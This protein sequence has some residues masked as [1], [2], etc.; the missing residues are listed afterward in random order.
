MWD[1]ARK[2]DVLIIEDNLGDFIIIEDYLKEEFLTV[3]VQHAKTFTIARKIIENGALF[4]LILLDLTLPDGTGEELV[5]EALLMAGDTPLIVLTGYSNKDFSIKTLAL[6]VSDYLLKDELDPA[7]LYKSISYSIERKKIANDLKHSEEKYRNLFNSSP[8]PMW[9]FDPETF[10]F[11]NVNAAACRHYGY[12]EEEFLSMSIMQIRPE[13][14]IKNVEQIVAKN[15]E[16]ANYY[17]GIFEHIKKNKDHIYVS[18]Q[19]NFIRFSEKASRLVVAA[20]VT[21]KIKAETALRIS[22]QRFKSLVQEGSDLICILDHEGNYKYVSPTSESILGLSPEYFLDKNAFDFIHSDDKDR[23]MNQFIRVVSEKRIQIEPYRFK[24]PE[25]SYRW[26]ETIVT[27]MMDDSSIDGVVANSRDV[28]D[29][30]IYEEKIRKK[31]SLF[32]ALI[33]KSS[34]MK[35]LI[36]LDGKI[37]FGTPSITRTLGYTAAEYI[38]MNERDLVH[39]D[40]VDDLFHKIKLSI[41]GEKSFENMQLRIKTKWGK[42]IWC[43][44][45]ITNL[46]DDPDVNAIVCNFWDIT[47]EKKADILIKESKDRYDLVAK[48]TSDA[49]WDYNFLHNTTYIAGSGYKQLFGYN[50]VNDY[51]ENFFWED[52]LHPEDKTKIINTLK[53]F[54]E[55]TTQSQYH[56]EYRFKKADGTYAYVNDRFF[57]IRENDIPV[58]II[59]AITDISRRKEEEHHLKLLES[60]IT[61]TNDAVMITEAKQTD[62]QDTKIIYVN[63][64]MVKMTGY[65]ENEMIG[66]SPRMFQGPKSDR[67]QLDKMKNAINNS[68]PCSSEIINYTKNGKL[69]WVDIDIA[70]VTDATG[71][72]SHMIAIEKDITSRKVQE[73]ER[74]KLIFELLQNNKDLR[75]FS[76][77]TSHNLR[78]PIANLLGLTNLLQNYQIEDPTLLKILAGIQKATLNFDETIK[79]LSSI[80]NVKDRP[81]I[82]K[83]EMQFSSIHEKIIDQYAST[84]KETSTLIK[85]DFSGAPFVNFNKAYLESIYSNLLTNAIKYKKRL[86][87]VEIT[88]TSE[89]KGNDVLLKF[90]DTGRG[91]DLETHKDKLFG[92]YQRFHPNTEGKGLGLFLVKSQLEALNGTIEVESKIDEGTVFILR[93]KKVHLTYLESV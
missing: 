11:L 45:T 60:I 35:T 42:Y 21:E 59:G 34:D 57:I 37:L 12:S 28:S 78:G 14:E 90:K 86:L 40:D 62:S 20:D 55:D 6:G 8:I 85:T 13:T 77:I 36:T 91:I 84:I 79:D 92:L 41:T 29:R 64:A 19:S 93:F 71:K 18:I 58:R 51:T 68:E 82:P 67:A 17:E 3:T 31:D 5:N 66:R 26:I 56:Y 32:R 46:L 75:Q 27:N 73:Q 74:E 4:D 72:V 43:E 38:G 49:I 48:A 25:G 88:I 52:R 54:I 87:P 70:P 24:K 69:Y 7:L 65:T 61:N 10:M 30:Y 1:N 83:E 23:V 76:Y 80:L 44:K 63:A 81:S 89:C 50:I 53:A 47:D 39:P 9:V 33:E 22:E 16:N 2:L 15:R